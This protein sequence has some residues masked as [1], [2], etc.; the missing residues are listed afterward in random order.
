MYYSGFDLSNY[1]RQR[2]EAKSQNEQELYDE[3]APSTNKD[4]YI[5]ICGSQQNQFY[6]IEWNDRH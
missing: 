1:Q 5:I 4:M 6:M 2:T 3:Q